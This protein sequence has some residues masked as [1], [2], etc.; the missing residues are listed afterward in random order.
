MSAAESTGL[1]DDILQA[2]KGDVPPWLADTMRTLVAVVP[3]LV[4][5]L[6]AA[7]ADPL[8]LLP[9]LTRYLDAAQAAF[10]AY[11]DRKD[12]VAVKADLDRALG[13]LIADAKFGVGNS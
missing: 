9:Y 5:E 8:I 4:A 2:V 6:G 13:D 11:A 12:P 3:P 1:V 10:R 7:E